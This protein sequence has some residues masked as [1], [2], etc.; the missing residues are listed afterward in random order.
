MT[1]TTE[2]QDALRSAEEATAP[3]SQDPTTTEKRLETF[4]KAAL[5]VAMG[6]TSTAYALEHPTPRALGLGTLSLRQAGKAVKDGYKERESAAEPAVNAL[7][8]AVWAAGVAADNRGLKTAGPAVNS[9]A[10]L[11]AAGMQYHQARRT[12]TD[13]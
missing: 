11:A 6:L 5:T 8:T 9:I 3:A 1:G 2:R 7:G 13:H 12:G 4:E 10:H